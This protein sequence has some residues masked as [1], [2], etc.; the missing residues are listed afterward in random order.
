MLNI[1]MDLRKSIASFGLNFLR[2]TSKN[3]TREHT[4]NEDSNYTRLQ[5]PALMPKGLLYFLNTVN[6]GIHIC[7][8]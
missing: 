6:T 5:T 4:T 1:I 8:C 2:I 7:I 3:R